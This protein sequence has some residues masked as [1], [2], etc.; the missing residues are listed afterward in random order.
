MTMV[1]DQG[2]PKAQ[3]VEVVNVLIKVIESN[4]SREQV[5]AE[6]DAQVALFPALAGVVYRIKIA[7]PA[8]VVG[9]DKIPDDVRVTLLS[10]LRDG[11]LYGASLYKDDEKSKEATESIVP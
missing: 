4:V 9:T 8:S 7:I 1:L 3:A 10:F 11:A 5:E 2:C 6:I